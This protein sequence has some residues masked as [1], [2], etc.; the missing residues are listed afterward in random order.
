MGRLKPWIESKLL[1]AM[2]HG[3]LGIQGIAQTNFYKFVT[4]QQGLSELGI[5][6][7]QPPKLLAAYR[8]SFKVI[9][10]GN[11]LVF[12]FG[13]VEAL[14]VGTPH[15]ADGTGKLNIDSWMT[16]VFDG[17][18]EPRGFVSRDRIVSSTLSTTRKKKMESRIRLNAP[19]GG[20][21]LPKKALDST[22]FWKFPTAL[23]NYERRWLTKNA[24]KIQKLLITQMTS[25]FIKELKK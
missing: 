10:K 15:P 2:I 19:L 13:D 25:A 3:G 21:M 20:L 8:D 14:K 17:R 4:S 11:M 24:V 7:S 23:R 12:K 1:P 18:A 5:D 16:W 22:G 6:A 9:V